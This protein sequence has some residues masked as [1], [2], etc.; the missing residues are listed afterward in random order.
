MSR[1]AEPLLRAFGLLLLL[2]ALGFAAAKAPDRPLESLIQAW[3]PPPSEF[4]DLN[5]QLLHIRDQGPAS[6]ALPIVLIHGTSASLH[7]WEGWVRELSKTRRVITFDL[8]G[9]GL[10]GPATTGGYSVSAYVQLVRGLLTHLQLE[11]VV[12]GG[13]S[14][15]GE[16][17]WG[18]AAAEPARVAGL[19]LVDAGGY[20]LKP[21]AV[22][23]GF[24]LAALPGFLGG[25]SEYMLPLK[26]VE[27][28]ISSV[29]GDPSK[30]SAELVQ[31]YQELNLRAGNRTA[32]RQHLATLKP[33]EHASQIA[34]LRQPTLILWGAK[35]RLIPPASGQAFAR[36]IKGSRLV[37][38]ADLGHVPHEEDPLATLAPVQA[39]LSTLKP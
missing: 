24:Q 36:D 8:P 26:L 5:G 37:M 12:L 1:L 31:R 35:D 15:G 13:N 7:T 6:D 10:T 2:A 20:G 21:E 11:R 23:L 19:I 29:Y 28:S 39:F 14:L 18:V 25:L 38:F 9:F 33:G 3:A 30:V 34:G 17:A 27:L 32:L 16:I 4:I 22:P